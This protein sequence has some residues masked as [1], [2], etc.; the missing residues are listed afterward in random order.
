MSAK[1]F[2]YTL[3]I[4]A[5]IKGLEA[6]LDQVKK[7][8]ATFTAGG[9]SPEME[10]TFTNLERTLTRLKEKASTPITSAAAFGSMQKD[11]ASAKVA[12]EGLGST[13]TRIQSSAASEKL[14]FIDPNALKVIQATDTAIGA[15]GTS[16]AAAAQKSSEL[17]TAEKTLAA[18]NKDVEKAQIAVNKSQEKTTAAKGRVDAARQ[19]ADAIRKKIEILQKW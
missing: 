5:E 10:K 13:I 17:I 19:E 7:S 4:D 16:I 18:A 12:L 14:Q 2:T 1:N 15:F 11:V 3:Q 9:K 8:M 6:K